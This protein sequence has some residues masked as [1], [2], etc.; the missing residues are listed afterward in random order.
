LFLS[1]VSFSCFFLLFLLF[2]SFFTSTPFLS[3]SR[4]WSAFWKPS[5]GRSRT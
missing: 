1:L 4:R 5:S 2:L 3:K